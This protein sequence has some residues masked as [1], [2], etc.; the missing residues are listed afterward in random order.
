MTCEPQFAII[1]RKSG[2]KLSR[3]RHYSKALHNAFVVTHVALKK[4]PHAAYNKFK[5]FSRETLKNVPD[6]QVSLTHRPNDDQAI[7]SPREF[8]LPRF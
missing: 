7:H 1:I 3:T 4:I 2:T 5:A 6:L 8:P